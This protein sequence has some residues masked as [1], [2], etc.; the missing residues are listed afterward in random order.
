MATATMSLSRK[1]TIWS[2]Q[3]NPYSCNDKEKEEWNRYSDFEIEAIEESLEQNRDMVELG[4]RVIDLNYMLQTSKVDGQT[5][6]VK[7]EEVDRRKYLRE[8]RFSYVE[9]PV[10]S[11]QIDANRNLVF[12]N[13]WEL[14][15]EKLMGRQFHYPTMVPQIVEQAAKGIIHSFAYFFLI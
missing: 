6:P 3:S 9:K 14:R 13:T 15:F 8:E 7:R 2:W 11:F 5:S 12:I 4:D 10:K 1:K